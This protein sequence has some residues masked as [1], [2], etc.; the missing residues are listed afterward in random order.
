[1]PSKTKKRSGTLTRKQRR[2]IRHDQVQTRWVLVVTAVIILLVLGVIGYGYINTYY[3][4]VQKASAVVYDEEI[5]VGDVQKEVRYRRLQLVASYNRLILFSTSLIDSVEAASLQARA[6]DIAD[7]LSNRTALGEAALQFLIEAKIARHEA[8]ERDIMVTD[9][10]VQAEINAMVGYIPAA[11]LTAMPS[12]TKTPFP[13]VTPTETTTPS[14]TPG[15]PTLTPSP[16]QTETPTLTPTVTGTTTPTFTPTLTPTVTAIPTATPFTAEAFQKY[17]SLYIDNIARETGMTEEEF[18]ERVRSELIIGKV[19]DAVVTDV[20][21]AEEQVHLAQI[22]LA[23][24]T[25]AEEA[26]ARIRG[27]E[28]WNTVV[29]EVSLDEASKAKN[30]DIG[31][32]A[33]GNPPSEI[34]Q[35]AFGLDK[36]DVSEV[37]QTGVD[38]WVI[39]KV[40]DKADRPMT[41]E[42]LE[43][44]QN[45]AYQTWLEVKLND[46]TIVEKKGMP[47]ELIPSKPDIT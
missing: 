5:T 35:T 7:A 13:S 27:G 17:Y 47:D 43:A 39:L 2:H 30:G 12:P 37:L 20:P 45:A 22:V 1:M 10:E 24:E 11:T 38:T 23:D 33:M 32:I 36:G 16:P 31:W 9:E 46:S 25:S 41:P 44:A 3:L 26:L 21:D 8:A 14:V 4:Q 29:Q 19:R 34:E 15:G 42:K 40:L 28:L 18:R 6:Q